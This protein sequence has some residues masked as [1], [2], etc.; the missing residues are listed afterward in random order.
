MR[1]RVKVENKWPNCPYEVDD[2]LIRDGDYYWVVGDVSWHGKIPKQD[3][4]PYPYLMR[5]LQWWED[6][7]PEDMP[8]YV[9]D[10]AGVYK[11][12]EWHTEIGPKCTVYIDTK[13]HKRYVNECTECP[14][15]S[16]ILPA[17]EAEY[18]EYIK[19]KEG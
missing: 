3:V 18:N 12:Q 9:K 6:R 16:D 19:Q 2:I 7:K 15:Y 8:A 10:D 11:V 14:L 1:H 13:I 17:T 4:E 5:P